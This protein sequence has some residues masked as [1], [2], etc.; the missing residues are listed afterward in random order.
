MTEP[1]TPEGLYRN[2]IEKHREG[3]ISFKN[4][5]SFNLEEYVGLKPKDP[6]S[7]RYYMNK[8]LFNHVDIS[9][10]NTHVPNGILIDMEKACNDYEKLMA[11]V[12]KIDLQIL[13]IGA[14]GH[15]GFNKPGT[16]F[17]SRTHVVNLTE[18]TI[19]ANARFF[20]SNDEVPTIPF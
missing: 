17:N 10:E 7:Y 1:R 3:K 16:R 19:E 13:G 2:L 4:M 11:E 5:I 6:Q 12:G 8:N 14:N 18:S 15:I 20:N 9:I